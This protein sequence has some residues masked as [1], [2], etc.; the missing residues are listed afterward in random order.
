MSS[1]L[2]HDGPVKG[3]V[4]LVVA[5]ALVGLGGG[6]AVVRQKSQASTLAPATTAVAPMP[7]RGEAVRIDEPGDFVRVRDDSDV[8][9]VG[10]GSA[11]RLNTGRSLTAITEWWWWAGA[12]DCVVEA[13]LS[14]FPERHNTVSGDAP[15]GAEDFDD[16]WKSHVPLRFDVERVL[17]CSDSV[18]GVIMQQRLQRFRCPTPDPFDGACEHPRWVRTET[19]DS[20]PSGL[21]AVTFFPLDAEF[22]AE[23]YPLDHLMFSHLS[24]LAQELSV[25][26]QTYRFA[27]ELL[28]YEYDGS[29]AV[30]VFPEERRLPIVDLLDEVGEA[31]R[32]AGKS[33]DAAGE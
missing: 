27:V 17:W 11:E 4:L 1:G 10:F 8:P 23:Y 24:G 33:T 9:S 16:G 32:L 15:V 31:L 12:A 28:W 20:Q 22:T 14:A 30:S 6:A 18:D 3:A 7:T 26:G 21:L 5:T 19:R 29:E 13:K 25:G 2:T